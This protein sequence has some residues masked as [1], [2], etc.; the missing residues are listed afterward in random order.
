MPPCKMPLADNVPLL[1]H[2]PT[3]TD[4]TELMYVR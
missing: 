4:L 3:A 2:F 1:S